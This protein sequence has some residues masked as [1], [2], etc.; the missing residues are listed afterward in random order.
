MVASIKTVLT[1]AVVAV[2]LCA[3]AKAAVITNATV[4]A[5]G[6]ML[7]HDWTVQIGSNYS[8]RLGLMGGRDGSGS[9][10][11]AVYYGFG[12][13]IVPAHIYIVLAIMSVFVLFLAV[14]GFYFYGRSNRSHKAV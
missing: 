4:I 11:T 13:F 7:T 2:S 1:I 12:G 9:T 14:T 10:D 6:S 8:H 5:R 3:D